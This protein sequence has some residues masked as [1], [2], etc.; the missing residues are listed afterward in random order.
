MFD[1]TGLL[2]TGAGVGTVVFVVLNA[3][4][5]RAIEFDKDIDFISKIHFWVGG[6]FQ[7]HTDYIYTISGDQIYWSEH[8]VEA[9]LVD[10]SDFRVPPNYSPKNK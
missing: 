4:K 3:A 2:I 9:D 6:F 10:T 5:Q 8:Y 1:C 7:G